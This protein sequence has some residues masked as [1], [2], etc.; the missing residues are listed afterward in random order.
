MA[1]P[2]P[3]NPTLTREQRLAAR[4]RENLR[5]R[6]DQARAQSRDEAAQANQPAPLPKP[7]VDG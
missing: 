3:T 1:R 2:D 7:P 6:K 5:R 4:L